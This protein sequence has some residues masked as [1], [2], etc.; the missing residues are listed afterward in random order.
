VPALRAELVSREDRERKGA[1]AQAHQEEKAQQ[2]MVADEESH[3]RYQLGVA[4]TENTAPEKEECHCENHG[5]RLKGMSDRQRVAGQYHLNHAE[6]SDGGAKHI[7]NASRT[8]IAKGNDG[9]Y[10]D[11][12]NH[13]YRLHR[14]IL[15][16]SYAE[17]ACRKTR[18]AFRQATPCVIYG[19][20]NTMFVRVPATFVKRP[21]IP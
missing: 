1:A 4:T 20:G 16:R 19:L 7:R 13:D 15:N 5:A 3:S 2:I 11:C 10:T 18:A 17:L 12:G 14:S 6:H 21:V 8:H 9:E